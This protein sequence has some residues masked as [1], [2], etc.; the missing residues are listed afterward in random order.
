MRTV[1]SSYDPHWRSMPEPDREEIRGWLRG[2]GIDPNDVRTVRLT[3]EG[4]V[5][6]ERFLRHPDHGGRYC[7]DLAGEELS[8]DRFDWPEEFVVA[9]ERVRLPV[10]SAPPA[11]WWTP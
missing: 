6:V 9:T 11:P 3:D 4:E 2:E 1:L 8:E 10:G 5:E 7:V